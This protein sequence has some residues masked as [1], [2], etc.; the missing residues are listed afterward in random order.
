MPQYIHLDYFN[1]CKFFSFLTRFSF[2]F[3]SSLLINCVK[4]T[5]SQKRTFS[6]VRFTCLV[7]AFILRVLRQTLIYFRIYSKFCICNIIWDLQHIL[8]D[9]SH[10]NQKIGCKSGGFFGQKCKNVPGLCSLIHHTISCYNNYENVMIINC[11]SST[12]LHSVFLSF[13]QGDCP[14]SRPFLH[15]D[16]I[17]NLFLYF[18][19][20]LQNLTF[21][22][23][24]GGSR[25][26]D[27]FRCVHS[28]K[29]IWVLWFLISNHYFIII[30]QR[31]HSGKII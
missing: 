31:V 19:L 8:V 14:S 5:S 4:L 29:I 30:I 7:L 21:G 2:T 24:C 9:Q 6:S 13:L 23:D 11:W 26:F 1:D 15:L 28:V 22:F 17:S 18:H 25:L 20:N 27:C 12:P 10:R 16:L 3:L